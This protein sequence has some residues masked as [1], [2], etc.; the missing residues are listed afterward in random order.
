M[1]KSSRSLLTLCVVSSLAAVAC[2]EDPPTPVEVRS[3]ISSDLGN[4]LR[5]SSGAITGSTG[6]LPGS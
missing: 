5:E 3:A 1:A 2:H 6:A 4:V